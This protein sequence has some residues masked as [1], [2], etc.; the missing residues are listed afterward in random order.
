MV[1]VKKVF[2]VCHIK[3]MS[4]MALAILIANQVPCVRDQTKARG[5]HFLAEC[6]F[7]PPNLT[8]LLLDIKVHYIFRHCTC[9]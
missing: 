4:F 7:P 6:S 2:D 9:M 1:V 8:A 3:L 5:R